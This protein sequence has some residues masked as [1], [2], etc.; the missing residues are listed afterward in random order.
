MAEAHEADRLPR[1]GMIAP[2]L[3]VTYSLTEAD[4]ATRAVRLG[5]HVGKVSISCL[6]PS[7]GLGV[8]DHAP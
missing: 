3:S 5:E 4:G 1:L 8:E 6:A 2:T 7:D